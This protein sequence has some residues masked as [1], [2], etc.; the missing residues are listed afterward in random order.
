MELGNGTKLDFKWNLYSCAA[1][2][3]YR[4]TTLMDPLWENCQG[5]AKSWKG[6]K[7]MKDKRLWILLGGILLVGIHLSTDRTGKK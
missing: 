2:Y 1:V 5:G 4:R 7:V 6:R 3:V